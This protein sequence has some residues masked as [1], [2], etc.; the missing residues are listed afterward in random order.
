M[1]T[2]YIRLEKEGKKRGEGERTGREREKKV[3]E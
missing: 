2:L 3:K 1:I